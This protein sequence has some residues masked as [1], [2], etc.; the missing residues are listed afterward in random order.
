MFVGFIGIDPFRG[1]WTQSRR[2]EEAKLLVHIANGVPG[3]V[4]PVLPGAPYQL[5]S[6]LPLLSLLRL[7]ADSPAYPTHI[8]AVVA[9]LSS[10]I[11]WNAFHLPSDAKSTSKEDKEAALTR[12]LEL[13]FEA[14]RLLRGVEVVKKRVD[15]ERAGVVGLRFGNRSLFAR[16]EGGVWAGMMEKFGGKGAEKKAAK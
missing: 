16:E 9:L 7:P 2:P 6:T 5:W 12:A 15:A 10:I 13:V 3:L 11:D 4:I 14:M 8:A 1:V